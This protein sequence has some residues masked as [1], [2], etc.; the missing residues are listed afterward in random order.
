MVCEGVACETTR[1]S[2]N[3]QFWSL[4]KASAAEPDPDAGSS[5][6][7]IRPAERFAVR[8]TSG[9]ELTL[10]VALVNLRTDEVE[11]YGFGPVPVSAPTIA[12]EVTCDDCARYGRAGVGV[13]VNV[14]ARWDGEA[15][16]DDA[17]GRQPFL[18]TLDCGEV[19][20]EAKRSGWFDAGEPAYEL[21]EPYLVDAD[22]LRVLCL[23][24]ELCG[25]PPKLSPAVC[26]GVV[27]MAGE[28]E[29]FVDANVRYAS[30]T[31]P[32]P[33]PEPQPEPRVGAR[34]RVRARRIDAR[35]RTAFRAAH[36][37]VSARWWR[38]FWMGRR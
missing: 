33:E 8:P 22:A 34:G 6:C 16:G 21:Q 28:S 31:L 1:L 15:G 3:G 30:S 26:F 32:E 12:P 10:R 5:T 18:L 13:P 19:A 29:V 9:G 11:P 20:C 23:G 24:G 27:G 25:G 7:S 38:E 4:E 2:P 35:G 36:A 17:I 14:R 37:I